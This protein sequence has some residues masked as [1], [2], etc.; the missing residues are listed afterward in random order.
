[1]TND[2]MYW[3]EVAQP[4]NRWCSICSKIIWMSLPSRFQTTEKR[5]SLCSTCDEIIGNINRWKTC[6]QSTGC[7]FAGTFSLRRG[8]SAA[9]ESCWVFRIWYGGGIWHFWCFG[10]SQS[11]S[12]V[13]KKQVPNDNKS[14]LV[15][16]WKNARF[17]AGQIESHSLLDDTELPVKQMPRGLPAV[18]LE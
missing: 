5:T 4:E 18:H 12:A 3:F 11:S 13:A 16:M 1:M 2:N 15:K 17:L 10:T 8:S 9:S 14:N 6:F 7:C